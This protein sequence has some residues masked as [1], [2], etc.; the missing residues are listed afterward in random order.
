[1]N[2]LESDHRD[3][4]RKSSLPVKK[5]GYHAVYMRLAR[6][7]PSKSPNDNSACTLP[8]LEHAWLQFRGGDRAVDVEQNSEAPVECFSDNSALNRL[9]VPNSHPG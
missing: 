7:R 9:R 1:M 8:S 3:R 5:R 4:F 6:G 2:E